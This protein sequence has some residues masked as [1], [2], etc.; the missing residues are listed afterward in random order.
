MLIK[1]SAIFKRA[2]SG[3]IPQCRGERGAKGD[4]LQ[5]KEISAK[6][7]PATHGFPSHPVICYHTLPCAVIALYPH[8]ERDA[9]QPAGSG[10]PEKGAGLP[11]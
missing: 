1:V 3:F 11:P 5:A 6:E 4:L 10:R 8:Q 9:C 7:A 2:A